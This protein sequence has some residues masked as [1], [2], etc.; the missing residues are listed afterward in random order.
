MI[1]APEI[2][3]VKIPVVAGLT[4]QQ[5][6]TPLVSLSRIRT[7]SG[8]AIQHT[9]WEKLATTISGTGG[10]PSG[11]RALDYSQEMT[12]KAGVP[13]SVTSNALTITLPAKRRGDVNPVAFAVM[14]TNGTAL[15][16]T[17]VAMNVNLATITAVAGALYYQVFYWPEFL[18]LVGSPEESVD[19]TEWTFSWSVT[20]EEV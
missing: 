11:L 14:G 3:G 13:R 18:A 15:K 6:F 7:L 16:R 12:M 19:R 5:T 17:A 2:G 8:A 9:V 4:L 10:I 20:A 1:V